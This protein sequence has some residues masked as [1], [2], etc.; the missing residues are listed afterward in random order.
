MLIIKMLSGL[1]FIVSIAWF[2]AQP[3]YEPAIAIITS[4][5]TFIAAWFGEKKQR[6][7]AKQNQTVS[8]NGIA[9][10]AGGDVRIGSIRTSEKTTDAE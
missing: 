7:R 2:I 6:R 8:E 4:L 9:I 3:D 1:V 5:S 10:Q